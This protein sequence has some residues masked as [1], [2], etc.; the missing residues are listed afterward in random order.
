MGLIKLIKTMSLFTIV[1]LL[2]KSLE[3]ASEK[4]RTVVS[5][6]LGLT[7]KVPSKSPELSPKGKFKQQRKKVLS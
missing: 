4:V 7:Q 3:L 1:R 5:L 6:T 2:R